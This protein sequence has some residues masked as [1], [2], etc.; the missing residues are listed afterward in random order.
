MEHMDKVNVVILMQDYILEHLENVTLDDLG[1]AAGYSKYHAYYSIE[2][3]YHLKDGAKPW[4]TKNV[5]KRKSV[6]NGNCYAGR[7]SGAQ[8]GTVTRSEH[9][10]RRL[11]RIL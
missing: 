3:Y 7:T 10:G 1:A 2:S 11:F 5:E 4:Q 6:K 8:A 9:G